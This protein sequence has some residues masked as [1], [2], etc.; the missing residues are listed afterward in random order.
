MDERKVV[1][2]TG[3]SVEEAISKGLAEL[4]ARPYEVIVEVLEEPGI[5]L[6]GARL[7]RVRLE[8]IVL[9]SGPITQIS[10]PIEP[11]QPTTTISAPVEKPKPVQ[12]QGRHP[13]PTT[14]ANTDLPSY[15]DIEVT[16]DEAAGLPFLNESVEVAEADL[17]E[18][19]QIA[20][21]VLN[22]LIERMHIRAKIQ[23]RRA[24]GDAGD[25]TPWILDVSGGNLNTLI[26]RRG[27]TLASLQYITRL[28]TSRELQRR[29][30]VI[31]DVSGYKLKRARSLYSLAIRMASDAV[32][33]KRTITLEP[34]PPHERR[35]IHIALRDNQE[36]QTRSVGEGTA[37]KVTIIPRNQE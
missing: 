15:M 18:E 2:T 6:M 25:G 5:G 28:I 16:E 29:S 30:G 1:E 35:I 11:E 14:S 37:R 26:G 27:D 31:V 36:V 4:N 34:M 17:D 22:E 20:R 13:Q 32:A 21:V 19:A 12:R 24:T 8:R 33:R 7:A 10:A 23:V 3:E 9:P